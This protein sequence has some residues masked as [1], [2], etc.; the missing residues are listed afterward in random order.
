MLK[1]D[2]LYLT[3]DA[4]TEGLN[5][6]YSRPW[7]ISWV[8]HQGKKIIEEFDLY[9]DLPNLFLSDKIKKLTGFD[10]KKY[11]TEKI[12][13]KKAYSILKP[14]LFNRDYKI[15]GQNI[16]GFD[17][18]MIAILQELAN[19]P[20]DYSY[21]E[22]IYDTFPLAKAWK[23]GLEKPKHGDLLSWQFK[24]LNDRSIK[25]RVTQ[26]QLLKDF[27]IDFDKDKLHNALYDVK[28]CKLNFDALAKQLSL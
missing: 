21:M 7:Q 3:I 10:Q 18:Y 14:K 26:L 11:D 1:Y 6:R 15:V 22:R 17:I 28:M 19:E 9:I 20:I 12:S 13:P 23:A 27:N 24:I 8:E 2:Q 25:K 16:L 5:L 4:E